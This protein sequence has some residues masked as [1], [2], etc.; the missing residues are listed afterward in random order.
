MLR[1]DTNHII[2]LEF[3]EEN[4]SFEAFS[5]ANSFLEAFKSAYYVSALFALTPEQKEEWYEQNKFPIL[6]K[7]DIKSQAYNLEDSLSDFIEPPYIKS[8]TVGSLFV[9]IVANKEVLHQLANWAIPAISGA[10]TKYAVG[11]VLEGFSHRIDPLIDR[12]AKYMIPG[13]KSIEERNREIVSR[14]L[15]EFERNKVLPEKEQFE[16][17]KQELKNE[18]LD[19]FTDLREQLDDVIKP[20]VKEYE[21]AV[22]NEVFKDIKID[23]PIVKVTV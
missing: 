5:A 21:E 13:Y 12:T 7:D 19:E 18:L 8:I 10:A 23:G 15:E 4:I 6:L 20:R 2:H 9:E 1:N 3:K 22:N 14:L 17:I 11:K 16:R